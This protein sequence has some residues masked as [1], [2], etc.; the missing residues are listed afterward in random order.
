[1]EFEKS[2]NNGMH[3]GNFIRGDISRSKYFYTTPKLDIYD[4]DKYD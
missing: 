1:M 4:Y 3:L 2:Y